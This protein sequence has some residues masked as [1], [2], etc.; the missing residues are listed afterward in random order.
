[1]DGDFEVVARDGTCGHEELS[2]EAMAVPASQYDSGTSP[3]SP[4][5][6][7]GTRRRLS[8][9]PTPPDAVARV[10]QALNAGADDCLVKPFSL[11]ELLARL[12]ALTLDLLADR[13]VTV[14]TGD[15]EVD[16]VA[17]QAR[18]R[19]TALALTMKELG[20]LEC[21]MRH[22]DQ[23]IRAGLSS[24]ELAEVVADV[25]KGSELFRGVSTSSRTSCSVRRLGRASRRPGGRRWRRRRGGR[26]REQPVLPEGRGDPWDCA[27]RP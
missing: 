5:T 1:V 20:I 3:S 9:V 8:A 23:L 17:R 18:V 2:K 7:V 15:L 27:I 14:R 24:I 25:D 6:R 16:T 10:V 21:L 12:R 22:P 19:G 4:A 11:G 13:H 26:H